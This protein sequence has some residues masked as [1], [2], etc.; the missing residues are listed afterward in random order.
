MITRMNSSTKTIL[1]I[2]T[3]FLGD[4]LLGVSFFKH[5][6]RLFPNHQIVLVTRKG[7]A[8][9]FIKT[10]LIDQLY[11]IKKGDRSTY[12]NIL[13][14]LKLLNIE[15]LFSPHESLRS[16]LFALQ[17]KASYKISFSKI[18]NQIFFNMRVKKNMDLPDPLRQ[19]QL[20]ESFDSQ[21]KESLS[22]FIKNEK[23]Y[24]LNKEGQLSAPPKWA[25]LSLREE[26]IKDESTWLR[27]LE[28]L[29]IAPI[30]EKKWILLFPGSVWATKRWV[31]K[32]FIELGNKLQKDNFQIIIMGSSDEVEICQRVAKNIPN[33][34]SLAG[35]TSIYESA[36]LM[37]RASLCIGNDSASM[38]LASVADIPMVSIFG[39]T[40]I[41]FGFRPWSSKAFLVENESL[42]CRPCGKHGHRECPIGTHECMTT[43]QSDEVYL[44]AEKALKQN[45]IDFLK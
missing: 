8:E 39:P 1:V 7:I 22:T 6:R 29:N 34:I 26:L 20:L 33:S 45:K 38:H 24:V 18:W 36:L 14:Q 44:K 11:E 4:L 32:G 30:K 17:L 35:A 37:L 25:S 13:K 40:V 12:Q 42:D 41:E 27:L 23:P 28:K 21:L 43:I 10:Q 16:A 15:Y 5:L 31:E 3:A 9:I 2:Q 19:L